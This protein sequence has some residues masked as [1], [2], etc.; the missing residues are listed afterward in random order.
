MRTIRNVTLL[1]F[2]AIILLL[3]RQASA[4]D[5]TNCSTDWSSTTGTD[6]TCMYGENTESELFS[7]ISGSCSY[8]CF[9]GSAGA[10]GY[11][12][13]WFAWQDEGSGAW[14]ATGHCECS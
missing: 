7:D 14:S 12:S 5:L 3:P 1:G 13:N 11:I 6:F 9:V 4:F 8:M 10:N 2:L